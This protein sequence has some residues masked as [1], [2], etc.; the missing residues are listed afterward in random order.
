[1]IILDIPAFRAQ[2]PAF[3]DDIKYPDQLVQAWFDSST[4]FM[5]NQESGLITFATQQFALYLLTAHLL[6]IASAAQKGTPV[7]LMGSAGEGTVNVG[8]VPPPIKNGFQWWLSAT[9]YGQQLYAL[10]Q[11]MTAGGFYA[12]GRRVR[13]GIRKTSGSFL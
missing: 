4:S 6:V 11:A 3:T 8:F 9:T 12:G 10:M 5:S 1:M 13:D 7:Q 2:F